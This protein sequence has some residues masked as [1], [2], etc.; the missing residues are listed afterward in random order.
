M[1]L[2]DELIRHE[3]KTFSNMT[4]SRSESTDSLT[5][6]VQSTTNETKQTVF[7]DEI[8][9]DDIKNNFFCLSCCF[10]FDTS[11]TFTKHLNNHHRKQ[12][13]LSKSQEKFLN[14]PN[15]TSQY[16]FLVMYL[17]Y[18]IKA[19]F[20][21]KYSHDLLVLNEETALLIEELNKE[22]HVENDL[23]D[24]SDRDLSYQDE[25]SLLYEDKYKCSLLFVDYSIIKLSRIFSNLR[26]L[27]SSYPVSIKNS[28]LQNHTNETDKNENYK[29]PN[30]KTSNH[31]VH[32]RNAC[33]KLKCPNCNWHYKYKETLDIHMR[34]KH[35]TDSSNN[36]SQQCIYCVENIQHPRLGRGEQY[37]CGYKPYRC[38][39]CDYS[40]TTKGNLSIHMQSDKH[41]NNLK[42]LNVINVNKRD[43]DDDDDTNNR[44][45][46][47]LSSNELDQ[48]KKQSFKKYLNTN[49]RN[50]PQDQNNS[51]TSTS[52]SILKSSQIEFSILCPLCQI[53]FSEQN[54]LESHLKESHCVINED[55][56]KNLVDSAK[57]FDRNISMLTTN[58]TGV[59]SLEN[60]S[61]MS[62]KNDMDN[63]LE[64]VLNSSDF[65]LYIENF[66]MK[67]NDILD[68]I[69]NNYLL[70]NKTL[71]KNFL[72]NLISDP[73]TSNTPNE[74]NL[75]QN[76]QVKC[77]NCSFLIKFTN[78]VDF[79]KHQ[80]DQHKIDRSQLNLIL[81]RNCL[82]NFQTSFRNPQDE[83]KNF[84]RSKTVNLNDSTCDL[85]LCNL[86]LNRMNKT[87]SMNKPVANKLAFSAESLISTQPI[88]TSP[89]VQPNEQYNNLL[90]YFKNSP[91]PNP[92]Q[93]PLLNQLFLPFMLSSS[94]IAA[95][96]VAAAAVA[97]NPNP[98]PASP[99]NEDS[100]K[101]E[102]L[103][104]SLDLTPQNNSS[105]RRRTRITEDQL[106]VLRQ[107][108][109]IN[110]SPTDEQ[111]VDIARRTQ[112]QGKVIK[113]WF[114]NTLFKER[115]KDKDSPY[116][117][118]N[119]PL[120]QLNLEEYEKT[121]K[122]VAEPAN[123]SHNSSNQ[124]FFKNEENSIKNE[125]LNESTSSNNEEIHINNGENINIESD[126]EEQNIDINSNSRCSSVGLKNRPNRTKFNE[127][128]IKALNNAFKQ[129]KYPKD[130]QISQLAKQLNLKPRV[131]TVWFQNA[132]QKA[133]KSSINNKEQD[134][135]TNDLDEYYD[136][137]D[138][139]DDTQSQ[140]SSSTDKSN[141]SQNKENNNQ[142]LLALAAAQAAQAKALQLQLAMSLLA[143]HQQQQIQQNEK[144]S[145]SSSISSNESK[146]NDDEIEDEIDYDDDDLDDFNEDDETDSS[147]ISQ[148]LD[149]NK[150]LPSTKRL[151]TTIL[152]EQQDFLMQK[153]QL[154]QNP[155]R[156]MLDEIAKQVRLK[157]RVVQVWFQN[158]RARE[159][160]GIIKINPNPNQ[161]NNNNN[162]N[163]TPVI[164]S[165][166]N[167]KCTICQL[168][169]RTKSE[170]ESHLIL[171]HNYSYE[172]ASSF[173]VD[174]N[175]VVTK[176]EKEKVNNIPNPSQQNGL[177]SML[178]S[179]LFAH[180]QQQQQQPFDLSFKK[181]EIVPQ[182]PIIKPIS[183]NVEHRSRS[184]SS[185]GTAA[186][187]ISKIKTFK[188]EPT[189][190]PQ[191]NHI[192][193]NMPQNNQ[194]RV[195][196]QMTQYQVNVM[197]LIFAEYKT[198]TMN[199]CELM[200]K[201]INLKKRVVQVWFQNA[202][203]KEKK[204][205]SN[206]NRSILFSNT[207]NND[208]SNFE[209]STEEC[210][211]CNVM[212][213]Q[214][215]LSSSG[216]PCG[217][218]TQQQRE[219]LFSK[220]HL[221]KL[222][223]FVSKIAVDNGAS[224]PVEFSK[225]SKNDDDLDESECD[226]DVN[227]DDEE[228]VENIEN[229][230]EKSEHQD[231]K[232]Q[233]TE[234][235]MNSSFDMNRLLQ[236]PQT[237]PQNSQFFNYF[238]YMNQQKIVPNLNSSSASSASSTCST[239][240][241]PSSSINTSPQFYPQFPNP[242]LAQIYASLAAQ[243]LFTLDS[244][245]IPKNVQGEIEKKLM[246]GH[247]TPI[248]FTLDN[249]TKNELINKFNYNSDDLE[250][251]VQ[252]SYYIC[253]VCKCLSTN[254]ESLRT[255]QC[256]NQINVNN[257]IVKLEQIGYKCLICANSDY[258]F[259][260]STD[261][262][263]HSTKLGHFMLKKVSPNGVLKRKEEFDL[264]TNNN[265]KKIKY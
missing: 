154:D 230:G 20:L 258:V 86:I 123:L 27:Y 13:Q 92:Q 170:L 113:H 7:I 222:I 149:Q 25:N 136:M 243:Q 72:H 213:N 227:T 88:K 74:E 122:I 234:A 54:L 209:F 198:P 182:S 229:S 187:T 108:F 19:K 242:I 98:A 184:S 231:F 94:P 110:K 10:K 14:D 212:Y 219:H 58:E 203:A 142:N 5:E 65:D 109:D 73:S 131:I 217:A 103:D 261:F 124:E 260:N 70:K 26:E 125:N 135:E 221:G 196:T 76:F 126:N 112:L 185:S 49:S 174:E 141:K 71:Y 138:D 250:E 28:D 168:T 46:N 79:K 107:Y 165:K 33:K 207:A 245:N 133:R 80:I 197:R 134:E 140:V 253:R 157:K 128:Q 30:K 210:L 247:A 15:L 145:S 102:N 121:G 34:E 183:Q 44:I 68:S 188:K 194:R 262:V 159:R 237:T 241:T 37:K 224:C 195:R 257:S 40:T 21:R 118:N 235:K 95:A 84:L 18:N 176:N 218:V 254:Q 117:F 236:I 61:K 106:K 97:T 152:P 255:H 59:K 35:S 129:Q 82:K 199:E 114:R 111:I 11:N 32:S 228:E 53:E 252:N 45:N 202:R 4:R 87:F 127:S 177:N 146:K 77:S 17:N 22:E 69:L 47:E 246:L 85:I 167:K 223:Q 31:I 244:L 251:Q 186:V 220:Q 190:T 66:L 105:R 160:K 63:K 163:N 158:T 99:I 139:C 233:D 205:N 2:N 263:E 104:E 62:Q 83:L 155:S 249:S 75:E 166:M 179:T 238:Y 130:E 12:V 36:M 204:N 192:S 39:I 48:N 91:M 201:E 100:I 181:Q 56:I 16:H 23:S 189:V 225:N 208:L 264:D 24:S 96:A 137:N 150:I 180:L 52:K 172:Q 9:Q 171:K 55:A 215:N 89:V 211:L 116:N 81:I 259:T 151:R 191:T 51:S 162:S 240:S 200:G 6:S 64:L 93:N 232:P 43:Q 119:P 265:S 256:L 173:V 206:G 60:D 143:A 50:L 164:N 178:M 144:S 78:L 156:K 169:F 120:T 38:D 29:S 41:M 226:D 3:F 239:N 148:K 101:S 42:E 1:N 153:Y 67:Y 175:E 132:R 193:Q 214:T 90:N 115:Q 161:I 57:K 8:L 147:K 248:Q 216:V